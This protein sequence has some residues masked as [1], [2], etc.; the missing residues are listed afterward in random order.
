MAHFEREKT[1]VDHIGIPCIAGEAVTIR[2][3]CP[4]I[5]FY[6]VRVFGAFKIIPM[7]IQAGD[8]G[9]VKTNIGFTDVTCTA[10]D[11]RVYTD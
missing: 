10:I 5:I 1:M 11:K 3:I 2:A 7:T 9:R 8:T 6:V 4:E